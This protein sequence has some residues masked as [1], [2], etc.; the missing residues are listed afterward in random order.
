MVHA[1]LGQVPDD[2]HSLPAAD[3]EIHEIRRY[4]EVKRDWTW[5]PREQLE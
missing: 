1:R 5:T 3:F 4:N 2:C